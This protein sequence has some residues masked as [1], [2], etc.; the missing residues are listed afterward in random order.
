MTQK[1]AVLHFSEKENVMLK[2]T[3]FTAMLV[4]AILFSA[5][6]SAAAITTD[7][8]SDTYVTNNGLDWTWASPV[9]DSSYCCGS[10][11]KAPSFHSGWRYATETEL[12]YLDTI[13]DLF[14]TVNGS[15]INSVSYWEDS[16]SWVDASNWNAGQIASG[17]NN[18]ALGKTY[19]GW[20]ETVYVRD[21]SAVPVP[22][23][24][25]MFT[26][27]LLGFMGFRR[28]AKNLVA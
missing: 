12:G 28:K 21:V 19:Q 20:F 18:V 14:F 26:P 23:A 22:A 10:T 7:L 2:K 9:A 6:A 4:S 17:I 5:H 8:A 16:V 25:F 11:L 3:I 24:L 27:A 15:P 1:M 13:L